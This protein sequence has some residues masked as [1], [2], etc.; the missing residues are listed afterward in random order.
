ML[1]VK[2]KEEVLETQVRS[3][4]EKVRQVLHT[5]VIIPIID[6]IL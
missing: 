3:D 4:S 6:K 2:L 1:D 5:K